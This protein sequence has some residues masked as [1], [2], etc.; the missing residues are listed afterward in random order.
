MLVTCFFPWHPSPQVIRGRLG[1]NNSGLAAYACAE[2]SDE[3]EGDC[4]KREEKEGKEGEEEKTKKTGEPLL[5]LG[6]KKHEES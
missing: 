1:L 6:E 4:A 2:D 5:L 3:D